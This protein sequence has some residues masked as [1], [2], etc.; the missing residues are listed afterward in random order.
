MTRKILLVDDEQ[1]IIQVV[2]IALGGDSR[3][4][5]LIA[6]DGEVAVQAA[7]RDRPELILMDVDMPKMNGLDACRILK[8]DPATSA[9]P[10]IMLT[11]MAQQRDVEDGLEA[12]ADDYITKPF[13]PSALIQRIDQMLE[14]TFAPGQD[15]RLADGRVGRVTRRVSMNAGGLKGFGYNIALETGGVATIPAADV[16]AL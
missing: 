6:G 4:E 16:K 2:S 8:N 5:L 13:S 10:V 7:N 3:F 11:A 14:S 1:I 15:I 9:I 12:G